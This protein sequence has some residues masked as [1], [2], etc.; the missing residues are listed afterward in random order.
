LI[1]LILS[2]VATGLSWLFYFH[3][4]QKGKASLVAPID[5]SGVA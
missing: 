3:A 5:K 4:L 2:G 1:F